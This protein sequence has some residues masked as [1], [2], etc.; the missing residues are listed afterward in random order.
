MLC[1]ELIKEASTKLHDSFVGLY[2]NERMFGK[3]E[4]GQIYLLDKLNQFRKI[5][6]EILET[7][8]IYGLNIEFDQNN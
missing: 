4:D 1:L 7:L 8:C 3:I 6:I 2:K 5:D